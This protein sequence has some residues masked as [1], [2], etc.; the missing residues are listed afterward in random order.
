M[1]KEIRQNRTYNG[2]MT[3]AMDVSGYLYNR[4][5]INGTLEVNG[6][7][8]C[9]K[10][11]VNG[12]FCDRGALKAGDGT[13]NGEAIVKGGLNATRIN[14]NGQLDVGGDVNVK[15]IYIKGM[16]K[17][18]GTFLS[19]KINLLGNIDVKKDCNAETFTSKG[20]F[21][22]G[23][24]LNANNIGI[25]LFGNCSVREIGGEKIEIKRI[26]RALFNRFLKYMVPEFDFEGHLVTETIEGDDIYVEYTSAKTVRGKSVRIGKGCDIGLV[27]YKD[28]F[29]QDKSSQVNEHVK[30]GI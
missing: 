16:V 11:V 3:G 7:M 23:G 18:N 8:D 21:V 15:E 12:S 29:E 20:I 28:S 1:V 30:T 25:Q 26:P 17:V 2:S 24:L 6:D 5:V 22:I 10:M 9:N 19:E 13:I 14:V 4:V 27:E